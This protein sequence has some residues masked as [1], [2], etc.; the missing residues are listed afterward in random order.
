MARSLIRLNNKHISVNQLQIAE[1]V[2]LDLK[3]ISA[4]VERWRPKTHT[5][6]LLRG[7]CTISLKDVHLQLGLPVDGSVVT[8]SIQPGDWEVV[9]LDLLSAVPEMIY[10][11]QIK[12]AWMRKTFSE[13]VKD[14]IEVQRE[15][16]AR[17]YFFQI[18]GGILMSAKL[19]NLVHLRWLPKLVDFRE[20]DE[21][22]W[23]STVLATLYREM[24]RAT[25]PVKIKIDSFFLLL[26]LWVQF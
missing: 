4:L 11:G 22:S 2:K 10:K 21:L 23:R 12:M 9:C 19:Q 25:Q 13:L 26:Q 5:F 15:Q 17:A 14:S 20:A 24:C 7:K 8:K 1:G 6:H 3:L 18:I 16:Y